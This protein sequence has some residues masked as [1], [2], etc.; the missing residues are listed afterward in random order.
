[1]SSL[2][3]VKSLKKEYGKKPVVRQLSFDVK[4]E[5]VVGLLGPNGAGKTTAFYMTMGLI[6]PDSGEVFFEGQNI[7]DMP[8][9]KR[10]A[11]GIGYLA[12]EP[13]VFADLSVEDNIMCILE[14]QSLSK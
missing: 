4:K 1:M 2:L 3:E 5:E 11:L 9:H 6:S 10:A 14:T 13:S 12:Q 7:T 8:V